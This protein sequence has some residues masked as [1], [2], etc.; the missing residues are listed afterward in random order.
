MNLRR[1]D[2]HRPY[3]RDSDT[4]FFP[5]GTI[6]ATRG[7]LDLLDRH[8]MNSAI[9]L[10]RHMHGDFGNID[11]DDRGANFDATVL[12]L[13]ILSAYEVGGEGILVITPLCQTSCRL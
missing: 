3:S 5:L 9:L 12:G 8:G 4:A 6:A 2:C 11:S 13:R 10:H 7:A 1:Q